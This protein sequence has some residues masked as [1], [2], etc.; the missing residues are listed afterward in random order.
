MTYETRDSVFSLSQNAKLEEEMKTP[1]NY[2]S[3]PGT[4]QTI[5]IP[6]SGK[7]TE[8]DLHIDTNVSIPGSKGSQ[9]FSSCSFAICILS[10]LFLILAQ[11][12]QSVEFHMMEQN[13]MIL[14]QKVEFL[15]VTSDSI[16]Q[17]VAILQDQ[18]N[19]LIRKHQSIV[20]YMHAN[21]QDTAHLHAVKDVLSP[22][23]KTVQ[24][25][26]FS[27]LMSDMLDRDGSSEDTLKLKNLVDVKNSSLFSGTE[28]SD[29]ELMS[30]VPVPHDTS[31]EPFG[32]MLNDGIER[33]DSV[34]ELKLD[35]SDSSIPHVMDI[36][37]S[38]GS[39]SSRKDVTDDGVRLGRAK[40]SNRRGNQKPSGGRRGRPNNK[41]KKSGPFV[42]HFKG[43]VPDVFIEEGGLVAPWNAN[44]QVAGDFLLSKFQLREGSGA[45]EVSEHG[46]YYI[47]AQMYYITAEST[48]SF[49]I[50]LQ[51]AGK[52]SPE[53]VA[54][55]SV[56]TADTRN[57]S[58]V[59]CFTSVVR[60][61][62]ATDRLFVWQRER[63]RKMILR[64][65]YSF[66]GLVLL[67]GK[68]D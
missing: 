15:A 7:Y 48:N 68:R 9:F 56:S 29:S 60:F 57:M 59:S 41:R 52:T 38:P 45:V 5:C 2:K 20:E 19:S 26:D 55:C 62:N 39:S 44:K 43:A 40:R 3:K 27:L 8:V 11:R 54:L 28:N 16:R 49:S 10:T 34:Q 66:F 64:D 36:L 51:E 47:Y 24:G 30:V 25:S 65:G 18:V 23:L 53:D 37:F 4:T 22:E 17:N 50:R 35:V 46:L 13:I 58:E 67:T 6:G 61:L 33:S 1:I 21:Y 31:F 12:Y 14:N 63:N 32:S 42:V